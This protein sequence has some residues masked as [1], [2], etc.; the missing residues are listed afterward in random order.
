MMFK[1]IL[2]SALVLLGLSGPVLG[3]IGE[4]DDAERSLGSDDQRWL[5]RVDRVRFFKTLNDNGD[6]E[7]YELQLDYDFFSWSNVLAWNRYF[8]KVDNV[9]F[10]SEIVQAEHDKHITEPDSYKANRFYDAYMLNYFGE[11][12]N[13]PTDTESTNYDVVDGGFYGCYIY[14]NFGSILSESRANGNWCWDP[15]QSDKMKLH[16]SF[17]V[18]EMDAGSTDLGSQMYYQSH[19]DGWELHPSANSNGNWHR[20]FTK[21]SSDGRKTRVIVQCWTEEGSCQDIGYDTYFGSDD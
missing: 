15:A 16:A 8:W 14:R 3:R 5:C 7:E 2:L 9:Y 1:S 19:D 6:E 13:P 21:D 17:Y 12:C 20:Y 4:E 11:P 18:R 10:K